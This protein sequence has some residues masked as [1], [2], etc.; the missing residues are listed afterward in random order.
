[1]CGEI[2]ELAEPTI[3]IIV[4]NC[5]EAIK[6]LLKP[7]VF[8]KLTKSQIETIAKKFEEIKGIPYVIDAVD[9]SHI[10]I[11]A[12]RRDP[13]FYY[14]CKGFYS[15]LLQKVVDA[16]CSFWDYDFK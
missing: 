11:I 13:A 8:Q 7:L 15:A 10:P 6:I 9:S 5:C 4:R 14:Y 3:S 1:M 2:Y 12:P 16:K